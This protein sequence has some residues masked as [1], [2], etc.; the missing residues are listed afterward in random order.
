MRVAID[1]PLGLIGSTFFERY[2]ILELVGHGGLSLVYRAEDVHERRSVILKCYLELAN[3][4]ESTRRAFHETFVDVARIVARLAH[5]Q[6]GLA[7]TLGIATLPLPDGREIPCMVLQWLD[8]HTLEWLLDRERESGAPLR[9]PA[10]AFDIMIAPMTALS[11]AHE[12]G[13][14]HRDIKPSNFFV[15]ARALYTGVP[16]R[17]VDFSLGKMHG[18]QAPV[19]FMTPN[20]AAPEQFAGDEPSIGPWTDVFGFALVLIEIMLGGRAALAGDDIDAL[21]HASTNREVRPSP[22]A[23]GLEIPA[24]IDTVFRRALAVDISERFA[25]MGRFQKALTHALNE[26]G[27]M[28]ASAVSRVAGEFS[29]HD[30]AELDRAVMH[31]AATVGSGPRPPPAITG[32]TVISPTPART[33]QTVISPLPRRDGE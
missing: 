6:R 20:Y 22:N 14:V 25:T 12:L 18:G 30:A 29:T 17:I 11:A 1:D 13:V 21:R 23:L 5:Q 15:G 31:R 26:E 32:Y 9:S 2:E 3:L 16:V 7:H 10:E 4:P 33:G 24:R 19:S 8:G 28:T 27:R